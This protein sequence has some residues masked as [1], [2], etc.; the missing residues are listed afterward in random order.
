MFFLYKP[1]LSIYV[2][3]ETA[4]EPG[5]HQ[6]KEDAMAGSPKRLGRGLSSLFT[7][8]SAE[9][10]EKDHQ[11][12]TPVRPKADRDIAPD[13]HP[14]VTPYRPPIENRI[15]VDPPSAAIPVVVAD[16][17]VAPEK[18]PP[19]AATGSIRTTSQPVVQRDRPSAAA[20]SEVAIDAIIPNRNQPRQAFSAESIASLA[21]SIEQS[22]IVQPLVVRP[23]GR[24]GDAITA[25]ASAGAAQ[26][27]LIAGERR[28]RAARAASVKMV[29]VVVRD[30]GDREA[31]EVALVENIQR[32]DLNAIDRA[33]AYQ[34]YCREFAV[35]AEELAQ[36]LGEDRS[37]IS[38]YMR[39]LE[40]PQSVQKLVSTGELSMGHARCIL[41]L[42]GDDA[43]IDVARSAVANAL[44]VRAVEEMVRRRKGAPQGERA[45]RRGTTRIVEK[46]PHVADLE[47][48][49]SQALGTKVQISEGRKRGSGKI[50]IEYYSLDDFDRI[51]E[52]MGVSS[53]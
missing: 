21:K 33:R 17:N 8:I 40:L 18:P 27:E 37:T 45:I 36:R 7:P 30:L 52:R 35:G 22:G 20:P 19:G 32:E 46:R 48:R 9:Q 14:S 6:I 13:A 51:S 29:P 12:T 43:R 10:E 4:F 31:L 26:F 24:S 3:R 42:D 53:D 15:H 39:L 1:S 5:T 38:N 25:D 16:S 44:S 23:I 49:M 47:N 41:G 34:G 2:P 11:E 50:L 28:W